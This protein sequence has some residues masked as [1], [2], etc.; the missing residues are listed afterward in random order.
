MKFEEG[1]LYKVIKIPG[2]TFRLNR[3]QIAGTANSPKINQI[4]F[5]LSLVNSKFVCQ[6]TYLGGDGR[7]YVT[8][9]GKLWTQYLEKV[10]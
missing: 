2:A 3:N 6:F 5:G 4:L 10:Q 1:K 8:V 7:L 9:V